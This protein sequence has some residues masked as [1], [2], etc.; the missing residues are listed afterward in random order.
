M[1]KSCLFLVTDWDDESCVFFERRI[2]YNHIY[3]PLLI[4]LSKLAFEVIYLLSK[5]YPWFRVESI[6]FQLKEKNNKIFVFALDIF[7]EKNYLINVRR[8]MRN[9]CFILD[10]S[11]L[12]EF[13]QECNE[14]KQ[15]D[16]HE[17][18]VRNWWCSIVYHYCL[19]RRGVNDSILEFEEVCDC[20]LI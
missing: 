10:N 13:Q 5:E 1:S 2:K 18:F 19:E 14:F 20:D 16:T 11:F 12:L 7:S 3:E 17:I 6:E 9:R 8:F 15:K 4:L